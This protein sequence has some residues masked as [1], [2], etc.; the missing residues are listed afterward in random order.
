MKGCVFGSYSHTRRWDLRSW[1]YKAAR[2][3]PWAVEMKSSQMEGC[4]A[5][6]VRKQSGFE[7]INVAITADETI[8]VWYW[9]TLDVVVSALPKHR[10]GK[11]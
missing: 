7:N 3:P 2:K 8:K 11:L 6:Q 10:A 1:R 5:G 9:W 4:F